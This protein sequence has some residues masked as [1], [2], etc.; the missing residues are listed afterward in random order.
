M[1]CWY[2]FAKEKSNLASMEKIVAES[3]LSSGLIIFILIYA[4]FKITPF[5]AL[6][7]LLCGLKSTKLEKG[8]LGIKA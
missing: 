1:W 7:P 3:W 6:F 5:S 2:V 8:Q 4:V